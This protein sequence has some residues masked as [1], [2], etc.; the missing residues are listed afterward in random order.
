MQSKSKKYNDAKWHLHA[1]NT[2]QCDELKFK[3]LETFLRTFFL[4]NA[5]ANINFSSRGF[6]P[7]MRYRLCSLNFDRNSVVYAGTQ[8]QLYFEAHLNLSC[9][10]NSHFNESMIT[11]LTLI[12]NQYIHNKTLYEYTCRIV[13]MVYSR[14][15]RA[16][17]SKCGCHEFESRSLHLKST[18]VRKGGFL[19]VNL[20]SL[21]HALSSIKPAQ[22]TPY[23]IVNC[24]GLICCLL[25]T[26]SIHIDRISLLFWHCTSLIYHTIRH[27]STLKLKQIM[28]E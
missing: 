2:V 17:D 22:T 24:N 10:I 23:F 25:L 13:W 5:L 26:T 6:R 27:C 3:S 14:G 4:N 16:F 28:S 20:V 1:R 21:A 15:A 9:R 18:L 19:V 12:V 8:Y 7:F 11:S